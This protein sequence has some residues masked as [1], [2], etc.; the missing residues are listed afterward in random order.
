MAWR[1]SFNV[2]PMIHASDLEIERDVTTKPRLVLSNDLDET[3]VTRA[4]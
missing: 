4:A 3:A 2:E 1:E